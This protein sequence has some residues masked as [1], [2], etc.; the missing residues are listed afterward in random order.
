MNFMELKIAFKQ[1]GY[2]IYNGRDYRGTG[3]FIDD[4]SNVIYAGSTIREVNN[5]YA[6]IKRGRRDMQ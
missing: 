2:E 4:G 6:N 3:Y 1:I 5:T